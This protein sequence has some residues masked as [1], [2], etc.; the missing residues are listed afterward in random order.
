[1]EIPPLTVPLDAA[2]WALALGVV[3]GV[4]S[5]RAPAYRASKLEVVDSLRRVG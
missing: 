5:A 3:L 2:L 1:M 4:L